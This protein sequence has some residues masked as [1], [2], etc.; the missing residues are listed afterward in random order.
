MNKKL[1]LCSVFSTALLFGAGIVN[2]QDVAAP[3]TDTAPKAEMM[4]HKGFKGKHGFPKIED[5]LDLTDAQKE[6]AKKIHEEGRKEIEP[7]MKEMKELRE[8]MDAVRKKNMEEFEKILTPE[9][10]AKFDEMKAKMEEKMKKFKDKHPDMRGPR[11]G[12]GMLP[13]HEDGILPPPPHGD[14][15]PAPSE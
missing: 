8:K 10:K 7:L 13:P 12:H 1:L 9:Q 14:V 3:A 2:A 15:P 5:K 4:H 6:Q 11:H